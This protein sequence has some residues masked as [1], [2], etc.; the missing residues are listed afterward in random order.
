M[1]RYLE[2]ANRL[3]TDILLFEGF[4]LKHLNLFNLDVDYDLKQFS[5]GNH[6]NKVDNK[7]YSKQNESLY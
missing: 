6:L 1:P 7:S 5:K 4:D 3:L 2:L